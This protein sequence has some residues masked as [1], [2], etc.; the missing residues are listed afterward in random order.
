MVKIIRLQR[1]SIYPSYERVARALFIAR[2][3]QQYALQRFAVI[4]QPLDQS[5]GAHFVAF[6]LRIEMRE[7]PGGV[8][9][10]IDHP[11]VGR[12]LGVLSKIEGLFAVARDGN[13]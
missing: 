10:S 8:K 11:E 3:Q 1:A 13:V 6:K 2:G 9:A 4:T 5:S 7:L 12:M